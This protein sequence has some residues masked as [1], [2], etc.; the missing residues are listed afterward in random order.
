M[1]KMHGA[2]A[3]RVPMKVQYF[4]DAA[5]LSRFGILSMPQKVLDGILTHGYWWSSLREWRLLNE[6]HVSDRRTGK[7]G[8]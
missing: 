5:A 6:R 1:R 4:V 2:K 3:L 7:A 8:V